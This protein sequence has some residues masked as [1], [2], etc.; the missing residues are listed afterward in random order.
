MSGD[1]E[2]GVLLFTKMT[3]WSANWQLLQRKKGFH[4]GFIS[5]VTVA[6]LSEDNILDSTSPTGDDTQQLRS[7]TIWLRVI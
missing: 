3:A 6:V 7:E 5:M 1:C 4:D 2:V